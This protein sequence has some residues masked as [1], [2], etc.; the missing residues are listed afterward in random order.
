[1]EKYHP[2]AII[3]HGSR[4]LGSNRPHSDWDVDLLVNV[5]TQTEQVILEGN[6][7]DVM[8]LKPDI[9]DEKIIDTIGNA[10]HSAKVIFDTDNVGKNFVERV[11][12]LAAKGLVLKPEEYQSKK[13]F[14]YRLINRLADAEESNPIVFDYHLGNFIQRAVNYSFQVNN[15]WSKSVYEAMKDIEA[16]N[17]ELFKELNL[18]TSNVSDPEKVESAKRIYKLIFKEDFK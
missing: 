11:Q 8:V 6:A 5:D 16:N 4:A 12:M 18:I 9:K 15:Q 3:L 14:L 7:V 13:L 10:F 17:P 2:L 1:M